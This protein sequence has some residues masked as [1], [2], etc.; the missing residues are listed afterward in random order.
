MGRKDMVYFSV[1]EDMSPYRCVKGK[2]K[3]RVSDDPDMNISIVQK[4]LM[5]YLG[6]LDH[7]F[8][9]QMFDQL[10]RG[11]SLVIELTPIYYSVWDFG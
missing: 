2:A 4:V 11:D 6:D 1:D 3:A 7:P 5:K 9:K 8:S 10:E